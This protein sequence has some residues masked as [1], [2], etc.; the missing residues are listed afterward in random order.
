MQKQFE[1]DAPA[2]PAFCTGHGQSDTHAITMNNG[3]PNPSKM[4]G[5]P[6]G[7][8]SGRE[9]AAM[10]KAP[11]TVQK[12]KAQWFIPSTYTGHDAR[13]HE[14]QRQNGLFLWLPVDIDENNLDLK[15]VLDTLDTVVPG[16]SRL[17]YSTRSTTQTTRKWRALIPLKHGIPG[18]LYSDTVSAFY[19]LLEEASCG[20]LIPD[21][22]LCLPGQIVYLPNRGEHYEFDIN[23]AAR[24]DLTDHKISQ[25]AEETRQKRAAAEREAAAERAKRAARR[26]EQAEDTESPVE[27]FNQR[28]GVEDLLLRYGYKRAGVSNDWRSPA[29][30]SGSYATRCYGDYWISLSGSDAANELG[31]ATANGH[32]HGDAFD[33]FVH[34]E[35]GG[36]F[37]RAV[38]VYA[39][40]VQ[41]SRPQVIDDGLSGDFDKIEDPQ[42]DSAGQAQ[43]DRPASDAAAGEDDAWMEGLVRNSRGTPYF[44][45]ANVTHILRHHPDWRGRFAYDEFRQVK[46][47]RMPIPGTRASKARFAPRDFRDADAVNAV[48]WFNRAGFFTATKNIIYDAIDAVM[49][50]NTHHP[51]REWLDTLPEPDGRNLLDTWLFDFC[52]VSASDESHR[53][54]VREVG[55]K[56]LISAVA[57]IMKPGCK[58]D[59]VLI[60]EGGQGAGKSTTLRILCG[61]DWFGDAL[62]NMASKDASDYLRGKWIIEMAELS[63]INKAEVEV[64]KAFISRTEERFRPA[65]ARTEITYPRQCI[66]AGSTNKT[67]YLRDET[68]NRR[69]WPVRV[70]DK[71]DLKGIRAARAQLW[72][73]ALAAFNAGEEWWLSETV[74]ETAKAQ[75]EMRVSQDAWTTTILEY[76]EGYPKVSPTQIAREALQIEIV[77]VDRLAINRITAVLAGAGY[78]RAGKL[79]SGPYRDQT[80]YARAQQ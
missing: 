4:A 61:D 41:L 70:S 24:L 65:Y 1:H 59:C 72:A 16:A 33:L 62:P 31:N 76:A 79:T 15:D 49:E 77:K 73:E 80:A 6:Y 10:V 43:A 23:K 13:N 20:I 21:R 17:V 34:Y 54:Y 42:Q 60:L 36:D 30:S 9:I 53:A 64:V 25:R 19:D 68:G 58:A 51:I 52:G 74:S 46:V 18:K 7:A 67:D 37:K 35:H 12:E 11:P 48:T 75:Q 50:D 57:R 38:N 55:R 69:F 66:F 32:R 63:N 8:V 71:C 22:R 28:N 78:V 27:H 2:E 45:T 29:Q 3:R 56:W 5:K 39:K 40:E 47:L 26:L 14:A 44:N